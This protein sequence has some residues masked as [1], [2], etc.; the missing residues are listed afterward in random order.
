MT[1]GGDEWG[2]NERNKAMINGVAMR[3]IKGDG[4]GGNEGSKRGGG[5]VG[6][7]GSKRGGGLGVGNWG[8][9]RRGLAVVKMRQLGRQ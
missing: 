8:S 3:V 7:W 6:N 9:K 4:W 1:I 2:D 5:W